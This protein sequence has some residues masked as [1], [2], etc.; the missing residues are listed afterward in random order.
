M[1]RLYTLF[2]YLLL[3]YILF[4]LYWKGRRNPDYR[5]RIAER[6]M[7]NKVATPIDI[8]LHGVSLGEVVAATPLIEQLLAKQYRLLI[9]TMTPAGSQY[10]QHKFAE[11]VAHQYVPYDLPWCTKRFFKAWRPRVGIIMETELWPNLIH[12]A[13]QAD[14]PVALMNARISDKAFQQYQKVGFFFKPV[15]ERL[16]FIGA[17]SELD[18]QRYRDLGASPEAVAML[19]NMK[20]DLI[21]PPPLT[22]QLASF[23]STWGSHR[24]VFI[25][26]S[27]HDDEEKQLLDHLKRLQQAIPEIILLIAP[28]RPER[29]NEVFQLCQRQGWKTARRSQAHALDTSTEVFVL[30]SLGELLGFYQLSDY[31]FVGGSLVPIGGHNV[32]EPIA[33]NVPT[34]CGP[35]MQNSKTICTDLKKANALQWSSDVEDLVQ[36]LIHLYQH[37]EENKAQTLHATAVLKANQGTVVKYISCVEQLINE[38]GKKNW[39]F[40]RSE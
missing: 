30:D 4:R 40:A 37:P 18:A 5:Q 13:F 12:A 26:A 21:S 38:A 10:V 23:K 29:F 3:P 11:R 39:S 15:L 32:L 2:L 6:F 34:L 36:R 33:V 19:G 28:R 8:W 22:E 7:L 1:R 25:A 9:T 14:I 27:T 17:Q 31:A 20:F 16:R 24:P 35:F